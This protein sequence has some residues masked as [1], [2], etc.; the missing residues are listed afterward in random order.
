MRLTTTR[1][2]ATVCPDSISSWA[3]ALGAV[4]IFSLGFEAGRLYTWV[5]GLFIHRVNP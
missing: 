5:L 2:G 1:R 3:L 4:L